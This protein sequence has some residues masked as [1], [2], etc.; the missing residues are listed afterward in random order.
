MNK[1][2]AARTLPGIP[3]FVVLL[4]LNVALIGAFVWWLVGVFIP[5]VRSFPPS[6]LLRLRSLLA[7]EDK[8][9]TGCATCR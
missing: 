5:A 3:S 8:C 9:R 2:R 1:E 7:T 4:V 6:F